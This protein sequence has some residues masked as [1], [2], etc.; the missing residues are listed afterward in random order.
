MK[1][2][3]LTIFIVLFCQLAAAENGQ[4]LPSQPSSLTSKN[5]SLLNI[6]LG[7]SSNDVQMVSKFRC[8]R[9]QCEAPSK[10]Y[11]IEGEVIDP[12]VNLDDSGR[13]DFVGLGLPYQETDKV[14]LP[15]QNVV[16]QTLIEKHGKPTSQPYKNDGGQTVT[17][18]IK[19]GQR[20]QY[21]INED[22]L[23]EVVIILERVDRLEKAKK[24]QIEKAKE[25]I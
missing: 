25:I 14:G 2:L 22:Q 16:L 15:V 1:R 13:V 20:L 7:M 12:Y 5:L 6:E 23:D 3:L 21:L 9:N 18:W 17:E 19:N 4:F 24:K 11:V 10:S 8:K